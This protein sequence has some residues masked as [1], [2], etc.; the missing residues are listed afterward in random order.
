MKRD[1]AGCRVTV[2]GLGRFGGGVGV[3]RHCA[4]Q[5]ARVLVTDVAD[6]AGLAEPIS[7]IEDLI[8]QGS[9]TL[10]LGEHREGDFTV[11]DLVVAN[12]A[13]AHP[14]SNRFLLAAEQAG[15]AVTTEIGLLVDRLPNRQRVIGVTGTAGKSTTA[16]MIAHILG[17]TV[18]EGEAVHL[19]GNIGG[20]LLTASI[21]EDDWVVLELSSAMLW[22]LRRGPMFAPHVAIVTSYAPNHLDWHESEEDYRACKASIHAGQR[23]GDHAVLADVPETW[24]ECVPVDSVHRP[25]FDALANQVEAAMVIPGKHNARNAITA[26]LAAGLARYGESVTEDDLLLL[27]RIA[28]TFPGLPHRLQLVHE[29]RGV[30][31]YNDSKS[32]TPRATVL[33]VESFDDPRRIHLIVGGYDKHID[34]SDL[35]T[36]ARRCGGVYTIGQVGPAL[37]KALDVRDCGTLDIAVAN[38]ARAA[39]D[40]DIVLLSPGCA[41]W[42]QFTNYEERGSVFA[43]LARALLGPSR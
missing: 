41:S 14:W 42:G 18:G 2:M 25:P 30:R 29:A 10:R 12:P 16:A 28:A 33:A 15:I 3:V 40:G 43:K 34:L 5:G 17:R 20:S 31:A 36:T 39:K 24:R 11:C 27:A 7:R 37:A 1:L 32:T 35:V 26:A 22:W 8:E 4:E 9:V 6:R 19:G 38:A 13:V 21:G 23:M